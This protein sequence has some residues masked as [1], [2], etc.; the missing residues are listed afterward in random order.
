MR[1]LARAQAQ[2]REPV[3]Y[4]DVYC[5]ILLGATLDIL[6]TTCI[7]GL[8]G[9]EANPIALAV[10]D[11]GGLPAMTGYK[12]ALMTLVIVVCEAVGR[13]DGRCGGRLARFAVA[14]N[15][16]PVVYG[17]ALIALNTAAA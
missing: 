4:P 9:S 11:F 10:L 15:A 14:A 1:A 5:W 12:L 8:G 17:A 6:V 7:L 2:A 16:L 13:R 3:L